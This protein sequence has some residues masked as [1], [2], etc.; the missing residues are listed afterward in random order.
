MLDLG[1]LEKTQAAID[2]IGQAGAEQRVLE[3]SRLRVGSVE[4]SHFVQ[5]DAVGGQSLH[6][7]DDERRFVMIGGRRK[8]PDELALAFARPQVLA[9]A[10]PGCCG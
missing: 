3:D 5:R 2:T 6:D 7:I 10:A 9:E 4:Q 8:G 1:A